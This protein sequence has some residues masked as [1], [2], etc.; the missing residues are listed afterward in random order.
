IRENKVAQMYSAI[1]TGANHGMTTLDQSLK[2]LVSKGVIS[3]QTARMAAK[4]PE[5]F[6]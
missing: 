3:P 5:A 1:Q 2:T 6:M 4:Q